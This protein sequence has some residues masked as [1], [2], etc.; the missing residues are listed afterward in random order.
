M[1]KPDVTSPTVLIPFVGVYEGESIR[2]PDARMW[3]RVDGAPRDYAEALVEAYRELVSELVRGLKV[4]ESA[5][6][7]DVSLWFT[8]YD[9]SSLS[10]AYPYIIVADYVGYGADWCKA[11]H[12]KRRI[13]PPTNPSPYDIILARI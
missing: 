2:F 3:A 5:C 4:I 6:T 11:F 7:D 13:A 10:P 9:A 1:N 8:V 12:V